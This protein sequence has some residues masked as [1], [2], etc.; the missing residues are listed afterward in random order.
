MRLVRHIA[1]IVTLLG[2]ALQSVSAQSDRLPTREE[3]EGAVHPKLSTTAKRGVAAE[4]ATIDIGTIE[5]T[6]RTRSEFVVRNTTSSTVVITQLRSTCSCLKLLTRPKA[7]RAGESMA[8]E[9]EFNPSGREGKFSKE[10]YIYTSLDGNYPTEKLT[11]KGE[12]FS[13]DE[14]SHLP[15]RMGVLRLSRKSV[16]LDNK[17]RSAR[18]VVVNTSANPVTLTSNPTTPGI[19]FRTEPRVLM[20]NVES[21]IVISYKTTKEITSEIESMLIIEG[22]GTARPTERMIKIKIRR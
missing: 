6:T 17:S 14:W 15:V 22:C 7:L 4:S 16:T 12:I 21:D 18:I 1:A 2:L 13:N 9:V 19:E 11:L 20:P 3:L 5:S 10:V 8:I